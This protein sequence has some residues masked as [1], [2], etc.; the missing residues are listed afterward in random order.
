MGQNLAGNEKV[1][2]VL[3]AMSSLDL[4]RVM[5]GVMGMLEVFEREISREQS[6]SL[7]AMKVGDHI[8][9]MQFAA[10]NMLTNIDALLGTLNTIC[11][12]VR[13]I[14]PLEKHFDT[15]IPGHLPHSQRQKWISELSK[16]PPHIW[17]M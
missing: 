8:A 4:K 17:S 16:L 3:L 6:A 9:Y 14:I 2:H 5:C 11:P 15:Q 7:D 13:E 10:G 1:D 12:A